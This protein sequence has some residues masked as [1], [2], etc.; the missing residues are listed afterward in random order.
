VI[1]RPQP[2]FGFRCLPA[3]NFF[4]S[5]HPLWVGEEKYHLALFFP[6]VKIEVQENLVS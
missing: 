1:A 3:Q 4:L 2:F 6:S 5:K